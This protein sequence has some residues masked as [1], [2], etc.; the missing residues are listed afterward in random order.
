MPDIK[1]KLVE[2][3]DDST[4]IFPPDDTVERLVDHLIA[5]GVT[6]QEWIPVEERLPEKG[7][8][9]VR[10]K[11]VI[12]QGSFT[13]IAY[14]YKLNTSILRVSFKFFHF[15]QIQIKNQG[16]ITRNVIIVAITIS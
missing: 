8:Y 7:K 4:V 9:L 16:R 6:I 1:E 5:N 2:L 12:C 3:L 10:E 14:L 11:Y 15:H 13:R